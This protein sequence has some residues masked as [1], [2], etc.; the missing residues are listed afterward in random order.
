[1]TRLTFPKLACPA[2]LLLL[3]CRP[4]GSDV[5][6]PPTAHG[7]N[8]ISA[9]VAKTEAAGEMARKDPHGALALCKTVSDAGLKG[10]CVLNSAPHLAR[11]DAAAAQEVC[12]ALEFPDECF[13]RLA[14]TLRDSEL[15]AQSGKFEDN[16][17]LHVL[18]FG[19]RHWITR[20]QNLEE[21][22]QAATEHIAAAG[23][24][25]DDA[26]PWTAIWRWALSRTTPLD[27]TPCS[28]LRDT[29]V[30]E[31]CFEAGVGL[32]HDQ[33]SQARD[34]GEDLCEGTL[35]DSLGFVEDPKLDHALAQR[36]ATDLC[37][38]TARRTAPSADLP[39]SAK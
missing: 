11:A 31:A 14:E 29:L 27:R 5:P 7:A 1:M 25:T 38:P 2:L 13:F 24:A 12:A 3:A 16:C 33:L 30:S 15:C 23:L 18:S 22:E 34:R 35:P 10:D 17:R 6:H 20:D 8:D 26:R 32:F 4:S 9:D 19:L 36:R 28:T 39:G 37:D 21:I